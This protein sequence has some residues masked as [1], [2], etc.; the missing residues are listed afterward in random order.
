MKTRRVAA[1]L[2]G[3]FW[4][5]LG[6]ELAAILILAVAVWLPAVRA[7]ASLRQGIADAEAKLS[8]ATQLAPV[9]AEL[10]RLE[11]ALPDIGPLPSGTAL[12]LA[13]VG[14]LPEVFA[15]MAAPLGLHLVAAAP[16]PG[17]AG[18][19]GAVA[20]RLEL[21]GDPGRFRE[22]LL[23]LGGYGPL[24]GLESVATEMHRNVRGYHVTCW[25][26]VQ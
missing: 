17:S 7:S 21:E 19:G 9:A 26:A 5:A 23:A 14:R 8:L 2:P 12:S 11:A 15:A 6:L 24:V 25:L 16:D 18:I 4:P 20:L 3:W 10:T 22:F 1:W 13:E